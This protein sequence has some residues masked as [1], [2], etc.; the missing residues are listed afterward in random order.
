MKVQPT[1][2]AHSCRGSAFLMVLALIVMLLV[3]TT[4]NNGSINSLRSELRA[5]ERAQARHWRQ[6]ALTTNLPANPPATNA[7]AA[8]E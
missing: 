6:T 3:I 4:A 8:H 1:M 7:G 2:R 5:L